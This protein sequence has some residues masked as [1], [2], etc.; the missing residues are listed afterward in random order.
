MKVDAILGENVPEIWTFIDAKKE[1]FY[2]KEWF[3]VWD[4]CKQKYYL[5]TP[6]KGENSPGHCEHV[7]TCETSWECR[8]YIDE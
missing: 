4:E 8:D 2:Y 5:F 7:F 6:G 3:C 1:S